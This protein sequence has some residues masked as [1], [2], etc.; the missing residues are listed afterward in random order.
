M[1]IRVWDYR[2]EYEQEREEIWEAIESVLASGTLILGE[3][4][5]SFEAEFAAFCD[6]PHGIGVNSGT[7]ALF[8]ALK[9][10]GVGPGMEVITV[11]NTAVPTVAAIEATG[12]RARF[13]DIDPGTFLM[14]TSELEATITPETRLIL[15]VHLYGQCA[16]MDD[17]LAVAGK[18]SLKVIE[19]CAQSHGAKFRD[20]IAGSMGDLSAFSFYPTKILGAYGDGG[21]LLAKSEEL[22]TKCRRLRF[23]GMDTQYYSIEH[24]YNSRLDEIHAAILR[25]KLSRLDSYVSRR[26]EIADIYFRELRDTSLVLPA[27]DDRNYHSFYVYVV[28]HRERDFILES[29]RDDGVFLNVSYR[30]P[31]HVMPAY[32]HLG[33]PLGSLP[34]TERASAEIFSLPMYPSLTDEEVLIACEKIKTALDKADQR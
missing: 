16:D 13:V 6:M 28:R 30:W 33:Y 9:A 2:K 29:L 15:P 1:E 20:N 7:D 8:L 18:H 14:N 22:N 34:E 19:D 21:M 11:S 27:V 23:Y 26:R 3:N 5:T 4:V 10:L 24:G 31:I 32:E 12:A 25:R 17:L